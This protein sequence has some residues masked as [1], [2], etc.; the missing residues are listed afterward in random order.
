MWVQKGLNKFCSLKF[1]TTPVKLFNGVQLQEILKHTVIKQGIVTSYKRN[2]FYI[3]KCKN[4]CV[5]VLDC[6]GKKKSPFSILKSMMVPQP[7][8]TM[9]T[10]TQMDST[11]TLKSMIFN[12][13]KLLS[14]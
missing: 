7:N 1:P 12:V 10:F 5:M 2:F 3:Y 4:K 14:T 6:D 9:K 13:P 11:L 8:V